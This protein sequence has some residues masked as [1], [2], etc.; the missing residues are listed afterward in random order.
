VEQYRRFLKLANPDVQEKALAAFGKGY[1][2]MG[3]GTTKRESAGWR[4]PQGTLSWARSRCSP[5]V[6]PTAVRIRVVW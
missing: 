3:Q 4:L 1:T 2:D 5:S 6:S